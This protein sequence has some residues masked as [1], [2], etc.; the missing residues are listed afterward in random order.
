[1]NPFSKKT[2]RKIASGE[3]KLVGRSTIKA[4]PVEVLMAKRKADQEAIRA[5]IYGAKTKP[6]KNGHDARR[7]AK[8][9]AW[10]QFSMFIRLR[11]SDEFGIATCCTCGAR[12]RW[13]LMDAGH[14][15]TT[16]KEATK[17]DENNVHAQCKGC[18]K[19]Q[20]GRPAEYIPFIERKYGE[21]TAAKIRD[22]SVRECK[23]T[24]F[25]YQ[26]IEKNYAE[27]VAW[28]KQHEPGKFN[29]TSLT[30]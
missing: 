17:F 11:D 19:W 16:V 14:Y 1:M 27:R 15:I 30:P 21:G 22:K 10:T 5:A 8:A 12:K 24:L 20:G 7:I 26:T 2:I 13:R 23:R 6:T 3:V 28:I 25:D 18:N 29:P 9:R 4:K